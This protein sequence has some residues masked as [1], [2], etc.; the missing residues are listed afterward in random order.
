MPPDVDT[1]AHEVAA[2]L[3]TVIEQ[4]KEDVASEQIAESEKQAQESRLAALEARLAM[5]EE[6][7]AHSG[8]VTDENA[9][10]LERKVEPPPSSPSEGGLEEVKDAIA[11]LADKIA[12]PVEG[13]AGAVAEPVEDVADEATEV[14]ETVPRRTHALFRKL[15]VGRREE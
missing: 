8:P 4:A 11:E 1:K 5:I 13:V 9:M 7:T 6:K 15:P 2:E 3:E 12:E 14:I 10:A